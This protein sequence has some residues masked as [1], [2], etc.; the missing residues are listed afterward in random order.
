LHDELC[1]CF[2]TQEE[3][4]LVLSTPP[5]RVA[6]AT[7]LYLGRDPSLDEKLPFTDGEKAS[8]IEIYLGI[9]DIVGRLND[10]LVW[11]SQSWG[12]GV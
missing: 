8:K 1:V 2:T 7:S 12:P 4:N 3:L 11:K 10:A 6:D 9:Y 5:L